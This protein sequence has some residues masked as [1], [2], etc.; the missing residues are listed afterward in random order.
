M[1]EELEVL[2]GCSLGEFVVEMVVEELDYFGD[3]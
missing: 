3:Y 2:L 1:G